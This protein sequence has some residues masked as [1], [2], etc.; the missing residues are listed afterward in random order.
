MAFE[1]HSGFE[2]PLGRGS[3]MHMHLV[4]LTARSKDMYHPLQYLITLHFAQKVHLWVSDDAQN[5]QRLFH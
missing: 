2:T 4:L 5:K 3:M 1:G